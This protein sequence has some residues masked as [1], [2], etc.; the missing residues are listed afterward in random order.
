MNEVFVALPVSTFAS[1]RFHDSVRQKQEG[2]SVSGRA[3]GIA[4][5]DAMD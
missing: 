4:R 2:P 5:M 3:V 1:N